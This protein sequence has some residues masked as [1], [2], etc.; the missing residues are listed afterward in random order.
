MSRNTFLSCITVDEN[1]SNKL[2]TDQDRIEQEITSFYRKLF[3]NNDQCIEIDSVEEFLGDNIC[4]SI[5]KL[6]ETEKDSMKG[7]LTLTELTA[8]LKRCRNN[9]SPGS[10]GFTN[11][12]YKFF[13]EI[14]KNLL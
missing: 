8:Y 14:L 13:G 2:L 1:G 7:Y 4:N 12:F 10:T 11:D 6:S 9:V 5:P 3:A